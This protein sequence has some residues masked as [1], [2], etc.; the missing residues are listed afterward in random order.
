LAEAEQASLSAILIGFLERYR[1]ADDLNEILAPYLLDGVFWDS[2]HDAFHYREAKPGLAKLVLKLLCSDLSYT[3]GKTPVS[4]AGYTLQNSAGAFRFCQVWRNTTSAKESYRYWTGWVTAAISSLLET[5]L[6]SIDLDTLLK[7]RTIDVEK[8]ILSLLTAT[9]KDGDVKSLK[10]T[11][12]V[13]DSRRSSVFA[14][15]SEEESGRYR[16]AYTACYYAARFSIDMSAFHPEGV[17]GAAAM[18]TAYCKTWYCIDQSYRLYHEAVQGLTSWDLLKDISVRLDSVY[19]DGYLQRLGVQW[20]AA[21]LGGKDSLGSWNIV[22]QSRQRDF[23]AKQVLPYLQGGEKRRVFVIISDA[24]RYEIG[25]ELSDRLSENKRLKVELRGMQTGLPSITKLGM[26]SL[27]PQTA[28]SLDE[29]GQVFADGKSTMGMDQRNKVLAAKTGI[30]LDALELIKMKR[31]ESRAL[32]R[33][34]SAVYLYHDRIDAVGDKFA[35]EEQT[36]A[37]CRDAVSDLLLIVNY[38]ANTLS[39]SH[40]LLTAD[41]GFIYTPADLEET[42]KSALPPTVPGAL[43]SK[44]RYILGKDMAEF[45]GTIRGTMALTLEASPLN[46]LLPRGIQRFHFKGGAKFFHGG[47]MPQETIVPLLIIKPVS[48]PEKIESARRKVEIGVLGLPQTITTRLVNIKLFQEEPVGET[49][50]ARSVR[51]G[52]YRGESALSDVVV[53]HANIREKEH[54]A[55]KR[56][57]QLHLLGESF[58]T[59]ATYRFSM[60]DDDTGVELYGQD[61]H[62]SLMITDEF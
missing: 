38:V 59:K 11:L 35:S 44:K 25:M 2:V 26:A 29:A 49:V 57:V 53:F 3:L 56:T 24:L 55:L 33:D 16:T 8:R 32:V 17:D 1:E 52:I 51:I 19:V 7:I 61:L 43:E 5:A 12:S 14:F 60:K 36:F 37:A 28:I 31:E 50:L 58:D 62:I 34:F 4:L 40:I 48:D 39:G 18:A 41:H 22:P 6:S 10:K 27:L 13:T 21:L 15:S 9:L 45:P 20:E 47:L 42:H 30:A 46:F 54:T 23:Y